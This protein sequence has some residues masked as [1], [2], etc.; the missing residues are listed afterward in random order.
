VCVCVLFG[1][2][3]LGLVRQVMFGCVSVCVCVLFGGRTVTRRLG[4]GRLLVCV[5]ESVCLEVV[6]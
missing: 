2:R 5:R 3:R 1:G 6:A 4:L